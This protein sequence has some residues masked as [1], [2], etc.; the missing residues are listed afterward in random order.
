MLC[1]MQLFGFIE[2]WGSSTAARHGGSG[3]I[4]SRL[5]HYGIPRLA[6]RA[7]MDPAPPPLFPCLAA[8][9]I[10]ASPGLAMQAMMAPAAGRRG[11]ARWKCAGL[12]RVMSSC[13]VLQ[14]TW[15]H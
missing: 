6:L 13:N 12:S 2:R 10:M 1:D 15:L 5:C 4:P 8:C 14:T 3:A 7:I 11:F 9:A